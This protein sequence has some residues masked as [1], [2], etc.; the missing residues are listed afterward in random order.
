MEVIRIRRCTVLAY[1]LILSLLKDDQNRYHQDLGAQLMQRGE[2][3]HILLLSTG[4]QA[5]RLSCL[6]IT[7]VGSSRALVLAS[8]CYFRSVHAGMNEVRASQLV[9]ENYPF[10]W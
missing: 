7:C 4:Y 8:G 10:S 6:V 2:V 3:P 1:E 9:F 5:R